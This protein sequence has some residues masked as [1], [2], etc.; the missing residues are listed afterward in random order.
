MKERFKKSKRN[1]LAGLMVVV[2]AL[3]YCVASVLSVI[4]PVSAVDED[5]LDEASSLADEDSWVNIYPDEMTKLKTSSVYSGRLV[6][7]TVNSTQSFAVTDKYFVAVQAHSSKE[8]AGW[9]VATD[10]NN[11]SSTPTWKTQSSVGHGNGATWNKKTNQIVVVDKEA[12]YLFDAENGEPAGVIDTG[13]IGTG[14]AYDAE[15]DWYV[16]TYGHR[17]ARAQMLTSDNQYIREINVG[18]RLM[19]Q[20]I[21]Y[22][23]GYVY[24]IGWG[25]CNSLDRY[26]RP[27]DAAYCREHFGEGTNVIYQFDMNGGFIEAFY[28]EG[29]TGELE[30]LDFGQDG[31]MYL[32]FNSSPRGGYYS[33]YKVT[34]YN[35]K[36]GVEHVLPEGVASVKGVVVRP[37]ETV[38]RADQDS[39]VVKQLR[40]ELERIRAEEAM[41]AE[42]TTS[43]KA[44]NDAIA[45]QICV[46]TKQMCTGTMQPAPDIDEKA[47]NSA[48]V[49]QLRAKI[50]QAYIEMVQQT[51]GATR[52]VNDTVQTVMNDSES[53]IN[54]KQ[55]FVKE[56]YAEAKRE[57]EEEELT[58][59]KS[60]ISILET[61]QAKSE[62]TK[63]PS[64]EKNGETNTESGTKVEQ[65]AVQNR[66]D[67]VVDGSIGV[68]AGVT[69]VADKNAATV[70]V[71]NRTRSAIEELLEKNRHEDVEASNSVGGVIT[72]KTSEG[73]NS[74][75]DGGDSYAV[76]RYDADD[77]VAVTD[78]ASVRNDREM[79]VAAIDTVE[80]TDPTVEAD[81]IAK[82]DK[83]VGDTEVA[84]ANEGKSSSIAL[85]KSATNGSTENHSDKNELSERFDT[86]RQTV[87]VA[88]V[89]IGLLAA[90]WMMTVII[91]NWR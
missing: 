63:Q 82:D 78:N 60:E 30:S 64:I 10:I 37:E 68:S 39:A 33:V 47:H 86:V 8:D 19:G 65:V 16:Q 11:P 69:T 24:R 49:E 40:A 52:S 91:R 75:I 59:A 55:E 62:E 81:E 43:E 17:D 13:I 44:Q 35:A 58:Y 27:E 90:G 66:Q 34:N 85:T 15:D 20:D 48:V 28:I 32:L 9:I 2:W 38:S 36:S 21:G 54:A 67:Y 23:N 45:E 83:E 61:E 77:Q 31:T 74:I 29:A 73:A 57:T 5:G 18:H 72:D 53:N 50:E 76:E 7:G 26:D 87:T 25:G 41:Q 88:V 3:T 1:V 42:Q 46:E 56:E 84:E 89:I 71:V 6:D 79:L 12:K 70:A 22:S 51:D 4:S 14:V 80:R